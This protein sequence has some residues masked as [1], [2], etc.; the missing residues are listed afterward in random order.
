M[1]PFNSTSRE[2]RRSRIVRAVAGLLLAWAAVGGG[3]SWRV[4]AADEV[5]GP[6]T[7]EEALQAYR[8]GRFVESEGQYA[9]LAKERPNDPRLRFNAGTA[10]YRQNDLTNAARWFESVVA[11]PDLRLQQQAY[12][13]LGNTRYRLGEGVENPQDRQRLI[14]QVSST[15]TVARTATQHTAAVH[16][17]PRLAFPSGGMQIFVKTLTGA[18]P[19]PL[20]VEASEHTYKTGRAFRWIGSSG[21]VAFE[22]GTLARGG[23]EP[24]RVFKFALLDISVD[25]QLRTIVEKPAPDHPLA[26]RQEHWVSMNLWSFTPRIFNACTRIAPSSRG[27]LELQDAVTFA[28]QEF[29]EPF[30][31]IRSHEPVLDL[32]SRADIAVVGAHL[33]TLHPQP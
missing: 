2:P 24:E 21:L 20:D 27:E 9:E 15:K 33:A 12:Y 5:A 23:M 1:T 6:P 11:A 22:A 32:S 4:A 19:L 17:A 13:N 31:I 3:P 14:S 25:E 30:H 10:A 7:P 28:M 29:G 8:K 18:I 26:M 16:I